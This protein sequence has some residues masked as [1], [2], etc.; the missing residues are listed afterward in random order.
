[1]IPVESKLAIKLNY[2]YVINEFTIMNKQE[3]IREEANIFKLQEWNRR[4]R[5]APIYR[6]NDLVA[7]KKTQLGGDLKL[8]PKFFGPYKVAEIKPHGRYDVAKVGSNEEPE[9]LLLELAT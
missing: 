3:T 7:I 4:R 1:M 5:T 8:K 9:E 2:D 6:I